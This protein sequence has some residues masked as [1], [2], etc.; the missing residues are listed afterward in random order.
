MLA[1]ILVCIIL[2]Y[3]FFIFE[4]TQQAAIVPPEPTIT[5]DSDFLND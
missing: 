3:P 1:D 4:E 2:Y 5:E